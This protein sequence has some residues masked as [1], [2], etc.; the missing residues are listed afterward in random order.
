MCRKSIPT[1][2]FHPFLYP[3]RPTNKIMP[4]KKKK[5]TAGGS[6][7]KKSTKTEMAAATGGAADLSQETSPAAQLLA[8]QAQLGESR[9]IFAFSFPFLPSS[10]ALVLPSGSPPSLHTHSHAFPPDSK[11]KKIE[12]LVQEKEEQRHQVDNLQKQLKDE[13]EKYGSLLRCATRQYKCLR[14]TVGGAAMS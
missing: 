6:K 12:Q 11:A 9:I 10:P 1:K 2:L 4:P 5:E 3:G 8:L 7:K 13:G 14:G